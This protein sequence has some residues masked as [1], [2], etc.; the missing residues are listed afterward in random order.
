MSFHFS[1]KTDCGKKRKLNEDFFEFDETLGLYIV[2]DGMGGHQAGDIASKMTAQK[3]KMLLK[4]NSNLKGLLAG[5]MGAQER[6]KIIEI[7]CLSIGEANKKVYEYSLQL[8]KQEGKS[9]GMGTTLVMALK[10]TH[11]VFIAHVGDSRAYLIRSKK[12]IQLTEDHSFVNE[13]LRAGQISAQEA[14]NHPQQ[15][16]ITRAVGA[17]EVVCPDVLFYELMEKDMIILCSDGLHGYF[18]NNDFLRYRKDHDIDSICDVMTQHALDG[19]GSDNITVMALEWGGLNAPPE[20]PEDITIQNKIETLKK[21]NLFKALTYKEIT[22][23]LEVIHITLIKDKRQ[24]LKQGDVG[25]DMF[26]ILKGEVEVHIDQKKV[27]DLGPGSYFGEMSLIDRSPRSATIISKSVC[28]LMRLEREELF[29]LLKH[30][31][32]IGLKIFWAFLQTMNQRLRD[33]NKLLQNIGPQSLAKD[34]DLGS[35]D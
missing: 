3:L 6:K 29:T 32:R 33:N 8:A 1:Y 23:L 31:P 11:G 9:A 25:E 16:V 28:K 26:V 20:H 24:I 34:W 19:G 22:Q 4:R 12:V 21:I 17:S 7:L 35:L 2:C 27:T 14:L 15:N 5:S 10:T 13:L 30:E 18:S